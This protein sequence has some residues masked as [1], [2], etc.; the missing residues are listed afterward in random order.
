[1]VQAAMV[2]LMLALEVPAAGLAMVR[3]PQPLRLLPLAAL[4][5]RP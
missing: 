4:S 2:G 5:G 3:V 1:M